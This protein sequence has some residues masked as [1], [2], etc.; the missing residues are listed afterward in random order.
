MGIRELKAQMSKAI[1][2]IQTGET[3][4]IT[5]HGEVV[6]YLVPARHPVDNDTVQ[7]SL[8][9]LDALRAEIGMHITEPTDV[10]AM[11]SEMRR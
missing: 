7:A 11:L 3:I 8:S 4:E 1:Q 2:D 10:V 5:N 6:A 9:S